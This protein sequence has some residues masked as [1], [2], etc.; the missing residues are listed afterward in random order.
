MPSGDG[1]IR[2]G[3]ELLPGP[4]KAAIEMLRGTLAPPGLADL[5]IETLQNDVVRLYQ[6]MQRL[7]AHLGA[8]IAAKIDVLETLELITQTFENMQRTAR[9]ERRNLMANV[10]INGLK[11]AGASSASAEERRFFVR[12]VGDL[13]ILHIDLLRRYEELHGSKKV[14]YLTPIEQA[15]R[16]ELEG[17]SLIQIERASA[18]GG[19]IGIEREAITELGRSFLSFLRTP[20]EDC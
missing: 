4:F 12:V 20:F 6:M 10:L 18:Y 16:Y 13:D 2:G 1:L 14:I 19:N 7:H 8:E 11:S 9:S 5:A 3:M 17:R 15:A